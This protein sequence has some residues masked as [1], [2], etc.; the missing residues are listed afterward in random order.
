MYHGAPVIDLLLTHAFSHSSEPSEMV[1]ASL[2][3][4]GKGG[5]IALLLINLLCANL[6]TISPKARD[7]LINV[8]L[9]LWGTWISLERQYHQ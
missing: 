8:A 2:S 1:R 3:V 9:L 4:Y 6:L 7:E 5:V